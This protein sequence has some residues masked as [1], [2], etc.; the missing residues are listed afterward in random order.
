MG[1][2]AEPLFDVNSPPALI[3]P[4]S[5]GEDAQSG[6]VHVH[7]HMYMYMHICTCMFVVQN[8]VSTI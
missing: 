5:L 3:V 8:N 4:S 1:A 2:G 6:H 7:A